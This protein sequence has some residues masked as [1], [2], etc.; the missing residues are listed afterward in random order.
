MPYL[1]AGVA[2][3]AIIPVASIFLLLLGIGR[4]SEMLEQSEED[5]GE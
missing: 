4:G 5:I 3:V 1:V 2:L